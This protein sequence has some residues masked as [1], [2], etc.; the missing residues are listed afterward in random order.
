MTSGQP[1]AGRV[2]L[3]T[4]GARGIGLACAQG[5]SAAGAAIVIVDRLA[6]EAQA[7][8][9]SISAGESRAVAIVADLA[10]IPEIPRTV[11]AAA[12]AYGRIDVLVNNAGILNQTAT[13]ALTEEQWDRLMSI[14]L[15]AV[16]F[17]TQAVLPQM[18]RQQSG[19]IVSISS[20]AARVGGIAA[21]IDY[22]TSKAGVIGLTRTLARQYGPKGIRVNAVAPGVIDTEMTRPWPQEVRQDFIARTPLRRLGTAEDVARAVVFLAGP[23]SAFITGATIDVNGG[24][25][26]S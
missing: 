16:F 10:Q 4:G 9:R 5:L 12:D 13:E 7:A 18:I 14:N 21:G 22:S 24:L 17:V 3:V 1:L 2:A 11:A 20:L 25:Y 23:E 15:K 19:A 26:M 6:Q 8:A